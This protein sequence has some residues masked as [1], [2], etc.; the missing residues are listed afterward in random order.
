MFVTMAF[1]Y[2]KPEHLD[3]FAAFL[4]RIEEHMAGTEGLVSLE[5]YRDVTGDRL[6]ALGRWESEDAAQA[7][8][9]RLLAMGGRDPQWSRHPDDVFQLELLGPQL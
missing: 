1:H 5:S 3:D 7:G 8:V 2:P 9:G 4:G 6:V